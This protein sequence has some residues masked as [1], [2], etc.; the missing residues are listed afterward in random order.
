MADNN[1]NVI[2]EIELYIEYKLNQLMRH[3]EFKITEH[4]KDINYGSLLGKLVLV[5]K[6]VPPMNDYMAKREKKQIVTSMHCTNSFDVKSSNVEA[7]ILSPNE[8]D[9]IFYSERSK[10]FRINS[11]TGE[12]KIFYDSRN[13]DYFDKIQSMVIITDST[14]MAISLKD[15]IMFL[16]LNSGR[17]DKTITKAHGSSIVCMA[18]SSPSSQPLYLFSGSFDNTIKMWDVTNV[19]DC[20]LQFEAVFKGHNSGITALVVPNSA[21]MISAST[22]GIIK[23]WN[24]KQGIELRSIQA[25]INLIYSLVLWNNNETL[26]SSGDKKIKM[27]DIKTGTMIKMLEIESQTFFSMALRG[28]NELVLACKDTTI[29]MWDMKTFQRLNTLEGHKDSVSKLAI[30]K[31]NR[32]VSYSFGEKAIKVWQ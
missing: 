20:G 29:I 17:C 3:K 18:V 2:N 13:C 21:E 28:E 11:K 9:Y 25:H 12:S 5:Q 6:R 19:T 4:S 8:P 31:N 27:W 14:Y 10:V 1:A 7:M 23:I 15:S 22:D 16:D 26:L 24:V 32:I 30:G